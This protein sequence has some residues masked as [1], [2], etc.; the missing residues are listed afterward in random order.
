[1]R[2]IELGNVQKKTSEV[3]LFIQDRAATLDFL[4]TCNQR[5]KQLI[6]IVF[7]FFFFFIFFLN[8]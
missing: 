6:E 3:A 1:M 4:L 5:V 7:G 8:R 2:G